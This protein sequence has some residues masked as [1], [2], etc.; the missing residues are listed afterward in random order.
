[1]EESMARIVDFADIGQFIRQPVK[2]YSSGM[3][4]R[5]AFAAAVHVSP[6]ILIVDEALAVGDVRF[7]QK[8][9]A[10]IRDFC[11][12]GTVLFVSHDTVA[13]TELCT[14]A[15]WIDGGRI[16]MD[17]HPKAVVEKYL[18][19]MY[20]DPGERPEGEGTPSGGP[21]EGGDLSGFSLVDEEI[22]QFGNQRVFIRG[23]RM[24]SR[25]CANGVLHAGEPTDLT[26]VFRSNERVEKPII[27]YLLKDRL[28]R[29]ILGEN[30]EMIG[31]PA[32]PLNPG[33]D[34]RV[35]FSIRSWPNIQGGEYLLSI[36]VGEGT[37]EDHVQCHWL[38]DVVVLNHFHAR[39][40]V[41]IF[42]VPD[43]TVKIRPWNG[44]R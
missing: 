29:I 21:E 38:H 43:T 13:V 12:T 20:G 23:V 36:A 5:L 6:D 37:L 31:Q 10:K 35:T 34:Y 18:E 17:D 39:T 2:F 3:Y 9:M 24:A 22:R 27:G 41:G 14:R 26:M 7:Q 15:I 11:R 30:T 8:C 28:G 40:P 1:V 32:P 19:H 42:S 4:V 44:D 33:K 16:R 25:G